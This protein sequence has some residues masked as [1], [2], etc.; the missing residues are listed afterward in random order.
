MWRGVADA[1]PLPALE[2][3]PLLEAYEHAGGRGGAEGADRDALI[4]RYGFSVPTDEALRLVARF[5]AKGVVEVGAGSG[6][7]A[8]LLHEAG[9]DVVAYDLEP[10]PSPANRWFAGSPPWYPMDGADETVVEHHVERTLVMMW[11]T[12]KETWAAR[13]AER[14]HAV[15][16]RHPDLRRG[17]PGGPDGRRLLSRPAGRL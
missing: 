16:G 12:R 9:V 6:Y 11:P 13:A 14:F 7:W 3:N 1:Q 17:G 15:G 8:R 5:A 2:G 10:P 4:A